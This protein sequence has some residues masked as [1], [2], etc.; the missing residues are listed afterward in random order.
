M[1]ELCE[2]YDENRRP[3]GRLHDRRE[4]L[5]P[6]EYLLVAGVWVMNS[7][8]ELLITRR[9]AQKSYAPLLWESPGGHVRPGESSAAC[10]ARE[11]EEETGIH[12][13][14]E[15]L[16]LIGS[17]RNPHYWG[18]DFALRRD[19]PLEEIVLQEG[20]TCQARWV[21]EAELDWMI[22]AEEL[23][24]STI[25]HLAPIREAFNRILHGE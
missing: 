19:V 2:L 23:A 9:A 13:C 22:A 24:P 20:E 11:L 25:T 12:A 1:T 17:T 8:K 3:L 18:D 4:P 6:G 7:R 15:E 16:I 10:A 5:G 21:S 14:P